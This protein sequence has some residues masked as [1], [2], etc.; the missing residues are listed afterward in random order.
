MGPSIMSASLIKAQPKA[1]GPS[2]ELDLVQQEGGDIEPHN[3]GPNPKIKIVAKGKA[4]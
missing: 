2:K 1:Q 4:T 3:K